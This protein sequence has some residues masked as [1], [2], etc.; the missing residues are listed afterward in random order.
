MSGRKIARSILLGCSS[1]LTLLWAQ[2]FDSAEEETIINKLVEE[3]LTK[4]LE[5]N[6][7]GEDA[8]NFG[9]KRSYDGREYDY[10]TKAKSTV[11]QV[12]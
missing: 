11:S 1:S 4:I 6:F 5:G 10:V 9:M 3:D 2:A 7:S 12:I 8:R